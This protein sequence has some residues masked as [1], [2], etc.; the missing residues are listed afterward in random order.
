MLATL[1]RKENRYEKN[2]FI[3]NDCRDAAYYALRAF[4]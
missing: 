3:F 1:S 2:R 4:L